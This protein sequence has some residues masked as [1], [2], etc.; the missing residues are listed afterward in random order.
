MKLINPE[1]RIETTNRCNANCICCS[2]DKMTRTQAT[3]PLDHF[4]NLVDQSKK[5]HAKLV[6]P[7]GFGEPFMDKEISAKVEYCTSKK[8]DTFL[9][10]NG[11]LVNMDRAR[12]ILDAGLGHI[13]FSVHAIFP[14]DYETVHA[15]LKWQNTIRN[16]LNFIDIRNIK[17]KSCKVSISAMP[18]SGES[19]LDFKKMWLRQ[20]DW[21]E[22]WYPH[23]WIDE[24]RYRCNYS[25]ADRRKTCGRPE[26]GPVQINADGKM[27]VC[28]FDTDAKMVIGDTYKNTIEEIL[29]GPRMA[30]IRQIHRRNADNDRTLPCHNCDQLNHKKRVLLFS[31]RDSKES[32][33]CT[34]SLKFELTKTGRRG[35]V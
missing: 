1:V 16:I 33:S 35:E 32:V 14:Y 5:L 9:T 11:S 8:M 19:V 10:T 3:M 31:S 6:S 28:C 23:N 21:L 26:F 15:G 7:F 18:L 27:I 25:T 4:K 22:V 29:N 30:E 20:V 17:Y 34:S 12:S 24:K 2:R 13:R